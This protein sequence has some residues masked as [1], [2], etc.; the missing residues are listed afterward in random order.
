[1]CMYYKCVLEEFCIWHEYHF[2]FK[3]QEIFYQEGNKIIFLL[4]DFIRP[5]HHNENNMKW[6]YDHGLYGF[7][8]AEKKS[9]R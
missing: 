6:F 5:L 9:S 2:S 3:A 7:F 1:M 8:F 4:N